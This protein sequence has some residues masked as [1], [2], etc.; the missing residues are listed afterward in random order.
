ML[1][2]VGGPPCW[3]RCWCGCVRR[4]FCCFV[5]FVC[6]GRYFSDGLVASFV[7]FSRNL[8][9]G[10]PPLQW[11]W[12]GCGRLLWALCFLSC[13]TVWDVGVIPPPYQ[14]SGCRWCHRWALLCPFR[15]LLLWCGPVSWSGLV[16]SR[17]AFCSG[18]P[19]CC[20]SRCPSAMDLLCVVRRVLVN[21]PLRRFEPHLSLS[22][23]STSSAA[24]LHLFVELGG[25]LLALWATCPSV[26]RHVG[27]LHP[28][29]SWCGRQ[30]WYWR[31]RIRSVQV[32][33][34]NPA[35][36]GQVGSFTRP[37]D[38]SGPPKVVPGRPAV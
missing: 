35:G 5:C 8:F 11:S 12:N 2:S 18:S 22:S 3:R 15:P 17:M 14:W 38:H 1:V 7:I 28:A 6:G 24:A 36:P 10:L 4:S 32:A 19:V 33:A 16:M 26:I 27:R 13:W 29:V 30:V 34:P 23:S 20:S 21:L 25:L 9:P 31:F 37:P